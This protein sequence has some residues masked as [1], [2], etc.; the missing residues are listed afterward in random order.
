[1]NKR[2]IRKKR[3]I[4]YK[5]ERVVL[6]DVLPYELPILFSNRYFYRFLLKYN[7]YIKNNIIFFGENRK[8]LTKTEKNGLPHIIKL[9]FGLP[10]DIS[11]ENNHQ[12]SISDKRKS[13]VK[14]TIPFRYKITHKEKEFR[15]LAIIHPLNQLQMVDFYEKYKEL[16]LY[17]CGRSGFSIRKPHNI[18]KYFYFKDKLHI[19][20]RGGVRR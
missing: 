19:Y 9:L 8:N 3:Y 16:I 5:K 1:M 20:K 7:V 10:T 12:I 11:I 17:A 18:A 15:E 4:K 13:K 6:S 14:R 2:N